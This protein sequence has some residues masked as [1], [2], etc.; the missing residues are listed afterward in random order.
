[1]DTAVFEVNK[2]YVINPNFISAKDAIRIEKE[3]AARD[4]LPIQK[5]IQTDEH[6]HLDELIFDILCLTQGERDAVH[7][8][9]VNLVEARLKKASSLDP[10]ERQKHPEIGNDAED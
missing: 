4:I 2:M 8:A 10:K 9:V 3:L 1:M 6:R 7:E 5:E